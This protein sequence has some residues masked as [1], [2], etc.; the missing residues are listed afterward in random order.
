MVGWTQQHQEVSGKRPL[1]NVSGRAFLLRKD[2]PGLLAGH[3][4]TVAC[5]LVGRPRSYN[6]VILEW[7]LQSRGDQMLLSLLCAVLQP[8]ESRALTASSRLRSTGDVDG[9]FDV[10]AVSSRQSIQKRTF[11]L[12]AIMAKALCSPQ[13]RACGSSP[14]ETS[15][16]N[17]KILPPMSSRDCVFAADAETWRHIVR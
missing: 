9:R 5:R 17:D 8:C 13:L 6:A 1:G 16:L 15:S 10:T 4:S 2:P 14:R 3:P 7:F 11:A 12:S